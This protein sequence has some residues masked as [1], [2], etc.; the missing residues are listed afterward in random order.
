[1]PSSAQAASLPATPVLAEVSA[2]ER[3]AGLW[4]A[5]RLRFDQL[6]AQGATGEGIKIAVIDAAINPAAAELQGANVKV[7]GSY[8]VFRDTG[9]PVPATSTT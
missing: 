7:T 8:C 3:V 2:E 5:D 4:Y 1:M 9:K 6:A